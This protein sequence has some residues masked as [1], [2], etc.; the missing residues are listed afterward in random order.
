MFVSGQRNPGS[1]ELARRTRQPLL[2]VAS[3]PHEKF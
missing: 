3:Q 1:I 2:K